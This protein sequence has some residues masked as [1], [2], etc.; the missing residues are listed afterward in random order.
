M[1]Y[2]IDPLTADCYEGTTCL[3]NKFGIRDEK[4]LSQLETLITT[5]KCEKLEKE[6]IEGDFG[7]K[8]YRSIHRFIFEDLYAWA[9]EVRTVSMSK[10]GTVFA[11]PESIEDLAEKIFTGLQQERCYIGYEEGRYTDAIGDLY[12]KINILHPFREG[13]GRTQRGFLAQVIRNSGRDINLATIDTD[14]LMIATI[15]SAN[16]VRDYLKDLFGRSITGVKEG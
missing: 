7:F 13:N 2:S 10:K 15:R 16:G 12:C 1:G 3:I 5:A 8:H 6:P 4:E 14:E 11:E 9:G